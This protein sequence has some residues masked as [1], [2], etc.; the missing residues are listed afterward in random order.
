MS[1]MTHVEGT[2]SSRAREEVFFFKCARLQIA[3]VC[4]CWCFVFIACACLLTERNG[5]KFVRKE[6]QPC[7][8][9]SVAEF[10]HHRM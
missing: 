7:G 1:R 9:L 3:H 8:M 4:L 5:K 10:A 6:V 2:S